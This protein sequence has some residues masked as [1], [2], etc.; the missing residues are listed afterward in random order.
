M[1]GQEYMKKTAVD[2]KNLARLLES[3]SLF[4]AKAGLLHGVVA[5]AGTAE[6]LDV[7]WPWGL[8]AVFPTCKP[9]KK[10]S[11][12]DLASL[13]KVVAT[14]S[15]CAICMDRGSIVPEA[16]ARQYIPQLGRFPGSVIRVSDLATHCS[17]Y[18]NRKFDNLSPD[19]LIDKAI[20]TPA[21]WPAR[22]RYEYSCRNFIVLGYLIE[23]ITGENLATFCNRELFSPAGMENTR[24]GPIRSTA[25]NVV[26]S[27]APPGVIEDQQARKAP[28][29]IGNAGLF[30]TAEDLSLFCRLLLCRGLAGQTRLLSSRTVDCLM[31]P[32]SPP[33]LP[34]RSFGWDMGSCYECLHRPFGLSESAIGHS[35]WTGQSIWID[36]EFNVYTIVLTN[37]THAPGGVSDNYE[38][39]KRFRA[40]IA[41]ILISH[42]TKTQKTSLIKPKISG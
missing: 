34:R 25:E 14:A 7:L 31:K 19:H 10:D 26:P 3:E 21:Q 33:H 9:M 12:F 42:V 18:D 1:V 4:A 22:K 27:S 8:A 30:S 13:T 38:A 40:R 17:G 20:R 29:P 24:F 39:S 15:A 32:C 36:P 5:A 11:L 2:V 35:G 16:P 37:R 41:E 23:R 28:R 6:T